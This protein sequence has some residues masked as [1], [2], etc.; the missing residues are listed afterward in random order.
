[1][2]NLTEKLRYSKGYVDESMSV[3]AF[4]DLLNITTGNRFLG[5]TVTVLDFYNGLSA[6]FWLING[7]GKKNWRLKTLPQVSSKTDLDN[8]KD[9]CIFQNQQGTFYLIDDGFIASTTDNKVYIFKENNWE[10]FSEDIESDVEELENK[11]SVLEN[12]ISEIYESSFW[13]NGDENE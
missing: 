6:D 9:I 4:N 3:S 2:A 12:K 11:V 8:I 10:L 1:M 7:L 5:V 13:I